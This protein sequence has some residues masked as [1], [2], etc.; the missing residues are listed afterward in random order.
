MCH[1]LVLNGSF[2]YVIGGVSCSHLASSSARF[3]CT[4]SICQSLTAIILLTSAQ[5]FFSKRKRVFS[6]KVAVIDFSLPYFTFQSLIQAF[7]FS[8]YLVLAFDCSSKTACFLSIALISW[9]SC[10]K[11]KLFMQNFKFDEITCWR[12]INIRYAR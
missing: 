7:F 4:C 10:R 12:C 6:H 3:Y 2:Y 11:G 1:L 9:F 8:S 5:R